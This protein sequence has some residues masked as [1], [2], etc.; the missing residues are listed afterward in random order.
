MMPSLATTNL[1]LQSSLENS[2]ALR[3]NLSHPCFNWSI[4]QCISW[5]IITH[6]L[7]EVV[8]L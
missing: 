3:K 7:L 1:I 6:E 5:Y 8:F 4:I 2:E